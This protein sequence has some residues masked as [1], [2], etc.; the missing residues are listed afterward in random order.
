[1]NTFNAAPRGRPVR[2]FTL[3][4]VLVALAIF[5][6]A[7]VVLGA[8]YS[9]L[10]LTHAALR[11]RDGSEN[12]LAWARELLLAEPDRAAVERGG[13]IVLPDGRN[14]TWRATIEPSSVSD[15]FDVM[16]ELDAPPRDGTGDLVRTKETLRLLRPTWSTEA[17]RKDRRDKARQRLQ[18]EREA[19]Q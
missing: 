7:A 8:A 17:E 13:D 14:A 11:D 10:M 3:I 6:I 19:M 12:D 15:L 18:R 16:L 2:A 4:E 1:M 9:N 5:A